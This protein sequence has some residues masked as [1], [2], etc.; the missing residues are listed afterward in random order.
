LLKA[1]Y[2]VHTPY[3]GHA[4]GKIVDYVEAAIEAGLHHIGFADHLG[5]YYLSSSQRRHHWDW[6]MKE[7]NVGRYIDEL[8][9]LKHVYCRQIEIRIGME[10][11]YVE[12]AE[13]IL[14]KA[15]RPYSFDFLLGSIHCIPLFGWKHLSS[16]SRSNPWPVYQ[17]YFRLCRTAV[18]SGLFDSLA[19]PDFVWRYVRWPSMHTEQ[20]AAEMEKLTETAARFDRAL[21]VNANAYLWSQ[22]Y[23]VDDF[24]PLQEFLAMA[25]RNAAPVS[26]GSDAHKPQFVAKWFE[27]L[28]GVLKNAGIEQYA[29]FKNRRREMIPFG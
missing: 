25:R 13:D 24:D 28:Q 19:H 26:I 11:D 7:R 27:H 18:E 10:I 22:L 23:S 9:E 17:E 16:Y 14:E 29:S 1:D 21:E 5:R 6:G 12:G 3:C 15:L 4:H 2:H 20:I 8:Q